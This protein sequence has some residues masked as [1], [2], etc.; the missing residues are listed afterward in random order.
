MLHYPPTFTERCKY[1]GQLVTLE[2][3]GDG[4]PLR[5]TLR[6]W[7]TTDH[8]CP[9]A[10]AAIR[11]EQIE[12]ELLASFLVG[13]PVVAAD[14][15][16]QQGIDVAPPF[17]RPEC[18]TTPTMEE[19]TMTEQGVQF[20]EEERGYLVTLLETNLGDTRVEARHTDTPSYLDLVHRQENLVRTLLDK[21]RGAAAPTQ[22]R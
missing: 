10:Q 7:Y 5:G 13:E 12:R 3:Q 1:C 16:P 21:L 2:R 9:E 19:K 18:A 17:F 6:Y 20:T 22:P 14:G 15:Q 8:L 11:R 4:A